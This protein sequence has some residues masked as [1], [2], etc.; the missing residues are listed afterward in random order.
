ME[1][2]WPRNR[3]MLN[4]VSPEATQAFH[5]IE[6]QIRSLP[7][8]NFQQQTAYSEMMQRLSGLNEARYSRLYMRPPSIPAA[9]WFIV[10]V[11]GVITIGFTMFFAMES[12]RVQAI[13]VFAITALICSNIML[14]FLV[15]Y[16]FD[17]IGITPPYPFLELMHRL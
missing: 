3:E 1:T 5:D 7:P 6:M 9:M 13:I 10:V 12:T 15:H 4:T 16:P 14:M 2:E 8:A 11:G 17:G